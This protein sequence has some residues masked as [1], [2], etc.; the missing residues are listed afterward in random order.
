MVSCYYKQIQSTLSDYNW[1]RLGHGSVWAFPCVMLC[2]TLRTSKLTSQ[3]IISFFPI[4]IDL[5]RPT[6]DNVK[7]YKYSCGLRRKR[8]EYI[9]PVIKLW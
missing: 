6:R 1:D 8:T 9:N 4:Y 3:A 5:R 2:R 7:I